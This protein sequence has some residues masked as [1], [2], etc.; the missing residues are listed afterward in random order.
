MPMS[1][2][3]RPARLLRVCYFGTYRAKFVRNSILIDG[4]RAQGVT[5][6]ECHSPLWRGISD[7][8][9]VAS[10]AWRSP[11]FWWRIV[12]AYL[13]L[14]RRYYAV[15]PY[16]V[17]LI[18]YPG[19]FD[20]YL[21]RL[22]TKLRRRPLALDVLMSLHLIA[23]ERGLTAKAPWTARLLFGLEKF[24][25]ALPDLLIIESE[26]YENYL[27]DKYGLNHARFFHV[28][29]GTCDRLFQPRDIV[30]MQDLR[31]RVTYHGLFLLSHG[32]EFVIQAAALLRER[33]DIHFDFY[34]EGPQEPAIRKMIDELGLPNVTLHG[35]VP[36]DQLLERLS[37][38]DIVLGVFGRTRQ[39]E[40]TIQN[41]IWEGLAMARPVITSD[42]ETIRQYL[43]HGEEV[44]LIEPGTPEAL[45]VAITSLAAD[46]TLCARLAAGGHARY[47]QS[48]SPA[49]LG[50]RLLQGLQRL[51]DGSAPRGIPKE[52][53][54]R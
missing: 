43:R 2:D 4:L 47:R 49:A 1:P 30:P 25:L 14:L 20:V 42:T 40:Y 34:G 8:E 39:S 41:K 16:D 53:R 46:P 9:E 5:I 29:H 51:A 24:G 50:A 52:D 6:I 22:L 45:A 33:T 23:E 7:R 15:G 48:H 19:H 38:S 54:S 3:R 12:V 44:Y 21:A 36:F 32:L 17:M 35:L 10:G 31:F 27:C 13:R 11:A 26:A 37:R 28:P 18:G